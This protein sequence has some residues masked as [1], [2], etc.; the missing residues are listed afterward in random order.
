MTELGRHVASL[1][2]LLHRLSSHKPLSRF[3][4][5]DIDPYVWDEIIS[6]IVWEDY[7]KP[8]DFYLWE[9]WSAMCMY[10]VTGTCDKILSPYVNKLILEHWHIIN[11]VCCYSVTQSCATLRPL[12]CSRPGFPFFTISRSLLKLMSIKSVMPS[13]HLILCRPLLLR[14]DP[15]EV[16]TLPVW[17]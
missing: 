11:K 9:M 6:H 4:E 17:Y 13:N 14:L 7:D 5:R 8:V 10:L 15:T 12:D 2:L 16:K 3:K 1:P